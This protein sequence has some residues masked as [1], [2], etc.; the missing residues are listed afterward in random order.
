M[1]NFLIRL[2]VFLF[3]IKN[4]NFCVKTSILRSN[5][6]HTN[7]MYVETI[8]YQLCTIFSSRIFLLSQCSPT[9]RYIGNQF[10]FG[11]LLIFLHVQFFG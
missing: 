1:V 6:L 10:L 3:L 9:K 11:V 2:M 8:T 5:F 7:Y 4:G